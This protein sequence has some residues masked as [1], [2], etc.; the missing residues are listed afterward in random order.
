MRLR[1]L[2]MTRSFPRQKVALVFSGGSTR[3]MPP[4]WHSE[5]GVLCMRHTCPAVD[6]LLVG[7]VSKRTPTIV[8]KGPLC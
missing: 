6:P 1:A 2:P 4:T 3:V 5:L 8:E 7:R